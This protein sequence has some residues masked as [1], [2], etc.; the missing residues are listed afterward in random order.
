MIK[1]SGN[2]NATIQYKN[3]EEN[4]KHHI[5]YSK[6]RAELNELCNQFD[7]LH[8]ELDM[9]MQHSNHHKLHHSIDDD[10]KDMRRVVE[11]HT[12]QGNII[13]RMEFLHN[14]HIYM[15]DIV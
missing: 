4:E 9:I 1:N 2:L 7:A 15:D 3:Y 12:I 14:C 5:A 8:E 13:E 10:L 11:I 6:Y